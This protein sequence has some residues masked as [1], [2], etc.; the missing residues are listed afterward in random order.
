MRG[1]ITFPAVHAVVVV[2][3]VVN[4]PQAE[5]QRTEDDVPLRVA[6]FANGEV[7]LVVVVVASRTLDALRKVMSA[8]SLGGGI[9]LKTPRAQVLEMKHKASVR[10]VNQHG[11]SR[12]GS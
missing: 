7:P 9:P 1:V 4:R 12:G 8:T 6:T 2:A 10:D 3:N 5:A 11:I